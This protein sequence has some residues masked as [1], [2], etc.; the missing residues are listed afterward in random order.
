MD[1]QK[2]RRKRRLALI[3][4]LAMGALALVLWPERPDE[5]AVWK[6]GMRARGEAMTMVELAPAFSREAQRHET[7]FSNVVNQL[8]ITEMS[9]GAMDLMHRTEAGLAQA[10]WRQSG[11][12]S[13]GVNPYGWTNARTRLDGVVEPLQQLR[14]LLRTIPP[15][16]AR[17]YSSGVFIGSPP[18]IAQRR[19]AQ[20]L[21]HAAVVELQ[22][23]RLD[24]A[25]ANLQSI[26]ALAR[27]HR[28]ESLLVDQM[29]GVAI[30]GLGLSASWEALQAPGWDEPRLALLQGELERTAMLTNLP[31][32]FAME[33]AFV[34]AAYADARTNAARTTGFSIGGAGMGFAGG[35]KVG[36]FFNETV[37]G[38]LWQRAWSRQDELRFLIKVQ[39]IGQAIR[40][41]QM[42]HSFQAMRTKWE[43]AQDDGEEGFFDR[44]RYQ[45]AAMSIPNWHKA[46]FVLMRTESLREMAQTAVAL[47]R[48]RLRHGSLPESL[49]ALVPE[50]L[51]ALP[52]DHMDGKPLRYER[53][54]DGSFSLHSVGEDGRDEQG[55]GDDQT[56]P[57]PEL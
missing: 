6:E 15:G 4:C 8:P 10:A 54:T 5:L 56:W 39:P 28:H 12:D 22:R 3:A 51:K 24:D 17:D 31:R 32:T 7:L 44:F 25:L 57:R 34:M 46:I 49:S 30:A 33:Q 37:Y 1:Y 35:G 36:D 20:F 19:A 38:P 11:P 41:A 26:F 21:T 40:E 13:A 43:Q 48:H 53:R 2:H 23:G 55:G 52:I 16:S 50:L 9:S 14:E 29:I 18:F 47:Q 27:L 42:N 45:L